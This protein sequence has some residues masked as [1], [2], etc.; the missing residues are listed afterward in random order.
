VLLTRPDGLDEELASALTRDGAVVVSQ[1]AIRFVELSLDAAMRETFSTPSTFAALAFTSR[2][3]VRSFA[4]VAK[5]L[6]LDLA[7]LPPIAA[8]GRGTADELERARLRATWIGD[9]SGAAALADLLARELP[10]DAVLL[11]PGPERP[12]PAFAERLRAAGMRVVELPLYATVA[13]EDD[14]PLPDGGLQVVL[15]S[16]SAARAFLARPNVRAR[17]EKSPDSLRLIA[18]GATTAAE[19]ERLGRSA[20]AIARTPPASDLEERLR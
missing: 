16:P 6:G 19:L 14:P 5:Q 11:H 1:P 12:E 9:G 13:I 10:R 18:G 20:A 8:V 2:Q 7:T 17:L 4:R 3:A 15:A